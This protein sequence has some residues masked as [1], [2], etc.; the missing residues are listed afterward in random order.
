MAYPHRHKTHRGQVDC[1]RIE[2][3]DFDIGYICTSRY[4]IKLEHLGVTYATIDRLERSSDRREIPALPMTM[5]YDTILDIEEARTVPKYDRHEKY[6][7]QACTEQ[8]ERWKRRFRSPLIGPTSGLYKTWGILAG[9]VQRTLLMNT[10]R[11]SG[12]N[13]PKIRSLLIHLP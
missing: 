3:F 2:F 7:S 9:K 11:R 5:L 12:E 4:T 10:Q 8:E 6:A 1:Q 13:Y